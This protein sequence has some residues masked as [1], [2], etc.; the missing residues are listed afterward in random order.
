VITVEKVKT[1]RVY[2]NA[3]AQVPRLSYLVLAVLLDATLKTPEKG[4]SNE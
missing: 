2:G 1:P 4:V 3:E